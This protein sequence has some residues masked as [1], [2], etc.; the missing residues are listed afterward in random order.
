M[1]W[2][3]ALSTAHWNV[4]VDVNILG[5]YSL[6]AY[7]RTELNVLYL[8]SCPLRYCHL[9]LL[10]ERQWDDIH[11][12]CHTDL[13]NATEYDR[14]SCYSNLRSGD[15]NPWTS[16]HWSNALPI[17]TLVLCITSTNSDTAMCLLNNEQDLCIA[18]CCTVILSCCLK[19]I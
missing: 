2:Y 11:I 10:Y 8:L 6:A 18:K 13:P 12:T 19:S 15:A 7:W 14:L 1:H 16:E 5:S 4:K 3:T 9:I 17:L